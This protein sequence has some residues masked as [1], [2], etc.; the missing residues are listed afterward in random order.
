[1]SMVRVKV[2]L[3]ISRGIFV[4]GEIVQMHAIRESGYTVI[5]QPRNGNSKEKKNQQR[6]IQFIEVIK[7]N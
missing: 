6:E 3:Q 4:Y 2:Q 5:K 7:H 1:M